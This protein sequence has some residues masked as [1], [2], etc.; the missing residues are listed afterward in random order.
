MLVLR[1]HGR[2]P[3]RRNYCRTLLRQALQR[4]TSLARGDFTPAGGSTTTIQ[5]PGGGWYKQ[6]FASVS[7]ATYVRSITLPASSQAQVYKIEFGAV[8]HQATLSINGRQV[9]TTVTAFTPAVFDITPYV[10]AGQT[11]TLSVDVKGRN[12]LKNSAGKYLVPDAAEWS[13]AIPQGIFRSAAL[14]IYPQTS[15]TDAFIRT[16]VANDSL[17]YDV[18]V[19]NNA[20]SAQTLTLSGS[21]SSWNSS[22]WSYPSLPSTQVTVA[23]KATTTVT[24]GPVHWGLGT[25]SYWWPNVPY[26]SGYHAQLHVLTLVFSNGNQTLDSEGYRFG[27]REITQGQY[28]YLN[29]VRVNFR[30]DNL[31]GADYDRIN[32]GGGKGDAYD[33]Y[34]GFLPPSSSNPGW[35]QAVDNYERLNYN[36]VRIHQEPASPYMLDTADEMGFMI[37]DE[38]AI[39]GSSNLQDFIGGHDNMVNHV[40]ALVLRDRNHPSVVRWSQSNEAGQSST[41]SAKFETDLYNAMNGLDGTRPISADGSAAGLKPES[42]PNF[43]IPEHYDG[44]FGT[45]TSQVHVLSDRPFG[46]GE[47]IWPSGSTVQGVTWFAT[48]TQAMRQKDASDLRPYAL[49]SAWAG[50]IPGV[51][52]TDFVTEEGRNPVYGANNL[53]N[54][55]SNSPIQRN[56]AAFNPVLVADESYWTTHQNSNSNGD[57][58]VQS[59]VGQYG[60]N[61]P[62]AHAD[63]L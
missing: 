19:S 55:W 29:G 4:W 60:S 43:T 25:G 24:V 47:Y 41:D 16:S 1:R 14:K 12:A 62:S 46:Q 33:T 42:F 56:Q 5:V 59:L 37:I 18:S 30:G 44:G 63:N 8:N 61:N 58:P 9:G 39:R 53:A 21:L 48:S 45:F 38:S 10:T 2:T 36:V 7:E 11:Y 51:R 28:W 27:F 54:P 31:Q 6:G 40:K 50:V 35:P 17:T 32:Y 26:V 57:W 22:A 49:L 23:A 13:E 20:S 15:I 34:P 52:T 3:V